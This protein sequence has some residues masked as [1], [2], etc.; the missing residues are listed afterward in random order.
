MD[1]SLFLRWIKELVLSQSNLSNSRELA[2]DA[3]AMIL[4][5]KVRVRAALDQLSQSKTYKGK[6]IDRAFVK[7][8]LF[9]SLRWY[10]KL[11]WIL[12]N[13]SKRNLD[14]TSPEIRAALVCGT[15]Q[16]YYMERIA[17]RTAVNESVEYIRHRGQANAV[18]F[19]NG[20][21]RQIARRAEYFQKPDRETK[22]VEYLSLQFAHPDW[23]VRRWL[24]H[25]KFERLETMLGA[26]NQR[27]PTTIRANSLKTPLQDIK[28]LQQNFLKG[29]RTHSDKRPLR[30]AV[31]LK[32]EPNLGPESLYQQGFYTFQ[33][34]GDQLI[35]LLAAPEAKQ[36]IAQAFSGRGKLVTHLYELS[37]GEAELITFPTDEEDRLITQKE[38]E[39]IAGNHIKVSP[40]NF[41]TLAPKQKFDKILLS[42]PNSELGRL[43]RF[44]ENKLHMRESM[45]RELAEEQAKLLEQCLH[46]VKEGGEIIYAVNSF[47][48][49]EVDQQ[50]GTLSKKYPGHLELV[51]PVP[52]LPDY[53]KKY[54][55]RQNLL[56]VYSGNQDNMDGL[57]AFIVRLVKPIESKK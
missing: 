37:Q 50:W 51:S 2:Y 15:F 17:D 43:R 4:T 25:F 46:L 18:S 20:I 12:Q 32:E 8:I 28:N 1:P 6:N 16:I 22:P 47:E 5:Q 29:E 35:G 52:R 49:E 10:S 19:V 23:M 48:P 24:R 14:E 21:L 26:S 45:L 53:Y 31:I 30:S 41:R 34:E 55:T 40:E 44:P 7:D 27:P 13:T 11:Y 57:G 38:V 36:V 39:R 56:L 33:D 42:P 3:F 54:V 9:G